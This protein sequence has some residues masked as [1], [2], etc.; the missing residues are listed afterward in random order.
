M[1]QS[2]RKIR[3]KEERCRNKKELFI[4]VIAIKGSIIPMIWGQNT[5]ITARSV[6]GQSMSIYSNPVIEFPDVNPA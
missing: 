3:R 1:L 4:A 6:Y 5:G 2:A